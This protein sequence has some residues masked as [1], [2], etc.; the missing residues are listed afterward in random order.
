MFPLGC[1]LVTKVSGIIKQNVNDKQFVNDID[2][3][4][5]FAA[6]MTDLK[7]DDLVNKA[8]LKL[9]LPPA[10]LSNWEELSKK[11]AHLLS[12]TSDVFLQQ[13]ATVVEK[14]KQPQARFCETL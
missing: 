8:E 4:A 5:S 12:N 6:S 3:L 14:A 11:L 1:D 10:G 13:H 7:V 2:A 9:S